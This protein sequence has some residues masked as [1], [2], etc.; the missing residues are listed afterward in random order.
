VASAGAE[1]VITGHVGP[2]AYAALQSGNIDIYQSETKSVQDVL[3]DFRQGRLAR[4]QAADSP[5]HWQG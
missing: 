1:A 3:E 4:A 5:P 2:K